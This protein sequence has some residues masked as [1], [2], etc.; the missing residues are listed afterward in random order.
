MQTPPVDSAIHFKNIRH[1]N[2]DWDWKSEKPLQLR[3]FVNKKN[4]NVQMGIKNIAKTPEE[5]LLIEDT[6]LDTINLRKKITSEMENKSLLVDCSPESNFAVKETY[7]IIVE[8][9]IA[10]FPQYFKCKESQVHNLITGGTFPRSATTSSIQLMRSL[11]GLMEEDFLL[12]LKDESSGEY[13]LRASITGFPAGFDPSVNLNK[14]ISQIH[15]PVPQ[16]V[17]RLKHPMSNFF[18]KL[19]PKDL[20]VRSNWSIQT[21]DDLYTTT[22]HARGGDLLKPLTMDEIDFDNACF[23]RVERQCFLRLPK[24]NGNLMTVRTYLTLI[25]QVKAEGFGDELIRS[26]DSLPD[27]IAFYKKRGEWG[28]AVKEYLSI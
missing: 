15:K 5:W 6:Y 21:H 10:R 13:I 8:Y 3:P 16:Y 28:D 12:L 1:V 25:K 2:D 19:N 26:I 22:N 4:F 24:S 18:E 27:E 14:T 7:E 17:P 20:W 23:L 9:F 11:V